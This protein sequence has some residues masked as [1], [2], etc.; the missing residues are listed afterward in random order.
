MISA[1]EKAGQWQL[2]LQVFSE[3]DGHIKPDVISYSAAISACEKAGKWQLA[4]LLF[5]DMPSSKIF[6]NI[7][8]LNA[9]IASCENRSELDDGGLASHNLHKGGLACFGGTSRGC[10]EHDLH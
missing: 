7:I 5:E 6:P 1:A 9:A 3:L 4:L 10:D 8:S 2:G